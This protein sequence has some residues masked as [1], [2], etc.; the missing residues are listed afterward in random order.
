MLKNRSM[1]EIIGAYVFWDIK[2]KFEFWSV[3]EFA[4]LIVQ[5]YLPIFVPSYIILFYFFFIF[6]FQL[7]DSC[8]PREENIFL[9]ALF[10]PQA[11][12]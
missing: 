12:P 4:Y 9:P 5:D 6:I 3:V 10:F 2:V 1:P 8:G 7:T 11:I